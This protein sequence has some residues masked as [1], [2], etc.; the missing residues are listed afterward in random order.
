[1]CVCVFCSSISI[2]SY[3][4]NLALEQLPA[5]CCCS[6]S[7]APQPIHLIAPG[8]W[9]FAKKNHPSDWEREEA[10]LPICSASSAAMREEITKHREIWIILRGGVT[11]IAHSKWQSWAR[12]TRNHNPTIVCDSLTKK[13]YF[14]FYFHFSQKKTKNKSKRFLWS[15]KLFW[16]F[17][18]NYF[19]GSMSNIALWNK[20]IYTIR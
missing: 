17:A 1:M 5:C 16:K 8:A 12:K 7:H 11:S 20:F 18:V 9:T 19:N 6:C 3:W 10:Y 2:A 4:L 14:T 13:I 15:V